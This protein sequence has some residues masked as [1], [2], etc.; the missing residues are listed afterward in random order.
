MLKTGQH[1]FLK[2]NQEIF[3]SGSHLY[4]NQKHMP[5][6]NKIQEDACHAINHL[7]TQKVPKTPD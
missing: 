1:S 5:I 7:S 4:N 6:N 2:Q 3:N